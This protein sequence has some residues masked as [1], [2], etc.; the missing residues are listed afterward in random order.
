V[1]GGAAGGEGILVP[2]LNTILV[3]EKTMPVRALQSI[4]FSYCVGG[5]DENKYVLWGLHCKAD[6]L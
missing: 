3:V 5:I 1:C 4:A 2:A 6:A